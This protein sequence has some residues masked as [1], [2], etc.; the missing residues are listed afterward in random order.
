MIE[1][2][3]PPAIL[4]ERALAHPD[5]DEASKRRGREIDCTLRPV[6]CWRMREAQNELERVDQQAG[7]PGT[8]A[9]P[10]TA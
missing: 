2:Y 9:A 4:Y 10:C 3:L 6:Y 7:M 8:T 5:F 1:R